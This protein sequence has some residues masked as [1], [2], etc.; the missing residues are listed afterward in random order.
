MPPKTSSLAEPDIDL[1]AARDVQAA[2]AE[3]LGPGDLLAGLAGSEPV[4]A[5]IDA[6]NAGVLAGIPWCM[7]AL[8]ATCQSE[9]WQCSWAKQDGD[10]F[11]AGSTLA[12]I[13][14][15]ADALLAAERTII[16]FLQLLCAVATVARAVSTAAGSVP[17][18]DT[19]KTLPGLRLAQKYAATI[20]GMH[21]NRTGLFDAAIIKDN[22]I[23]AVG[24]ITKALAQAAPPAS[25]NIQIE[26]SNL[27]QLDEALAAG[28]KRIMLDNFSVDQARSAV[29]TVA[30]QAELEASGGITAANAAAYAATGVDRLSCGAVTKE[31]Q[32]ID[33]T[34][35]LEG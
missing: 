8:A 14:A 30:G 19:R 1:L 35:V 9:P 2:L 28:A 13:T 27:E 12:V 11:P 29:A 15:P 32:A 22:H 16:N 33:L 31:I 4:R 20:G 25:T 7:A 17:V 5:R 23:S 6:R 21:R 34:L 3:D 26:V 24:S 10:S 18:F